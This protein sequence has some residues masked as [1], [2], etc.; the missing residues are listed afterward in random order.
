MNL[1][2][3]GL[4]AA[5]LL[6]FVV[7]ATRQRIFLLGV[8]FLLYMGDSVF[9][10]KLKPFWIPARL[11]YA[12]H[13]MIWLVIVWVVYFDLLLPARH[14]SGERR[15]PFGPAL[16]APEELVLAG[17]AALV[18]V[19]IA[20]TALR[21]G[22]LGAT[23]GQA[24][25]FV[26]LF[27]GYFLL[28]GMLCRAGR[29]DT[30]DFIKVLVVANTVTAVLFI[31][32]QGLHMSIYPFVANK[33][34]SFAGQTLT[35]SFYFMPQLVSLALAYCLA[36]RAWG[37]FWLGV[38]VVTLGTVWVS[39]TR[40][41]LIVAAAEVLVVLGVRLLK[42]HQAGLAVKRGLALA[43]IAVVVGAVAFTFLPVE[44]HYFLSRIHSTTKTGSATGD[45]DL[46]I[47]ITDLR[48]AWQY[49]APESHL[50][51]QGFA[52][53]QQDPAGASVSSN[54]SDIVWMQVLYNLG[55]VGALLLVGLYVC[56]SWRALQ[57]SVSGN[58]DAEFLAVVLLGTLVGTFLEG[59][60]SWTFLN[61][62]N[63]A[64]GFWLFAL[65]AA[66]VAR[67]RAESASLPAAEG[68]GDRS[69]DSVAA[70]AATAT[71]LAERLG[72]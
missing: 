49:I 35:R 56:A 39:Y 11:S 23:L 33:T 36:K 22:E 69:D 16:S 48:H 4:P 7:R 71:P 24:K 26:Y 18:V 47:R 20:F 27:A 38:L 28:R 63:Y 14:R 52:T 62:N 50:F 31:A 2:R 61:P 54:T 1:L 46:Q 57:M 44:S 5:L 45:P 64:M 65:L 42:A 10:H 3:L 67:R 21:F 58:G 41:L 19:E 59:L 40:S 72:A 17:I 25:G 66:E 68:S 6:Y 29:R 43:G 12:D 37:I 70:H 9:A 51:G 55:L 53:P 15:R 32:D 34:I 13:L 60:V 30:L 8:P